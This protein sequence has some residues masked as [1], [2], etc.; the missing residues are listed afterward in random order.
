[1]NRLHSL[2]VLMFGLTGLLSGCDSKLPIKQLPSQVTL[3]IHDADGDVASRQE[4]K[5]PD[6]VYQGL[7]R[8]LASNPTGWQVNVASYKPGRFVFRAGHTVIRCY[9]SFLIIDYKEGNRLESRR[10]DI[11]DVFAK[12]GLVPGMP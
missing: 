2:L 4:L 12:I 3:E 8:L 10:K 1:M 5:A 11:P 6:P 9:D 7:N